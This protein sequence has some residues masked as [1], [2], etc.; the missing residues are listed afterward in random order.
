MIAVLLLVARM[1]TFW[2]MSPGPAPT[3]VRLTVR[4]P[5]FSRTVTSEIGSIVGTWLTGRT[6]TL[7]VREKVFTPP[8]AV[9]PLSVTVTVIVAVP[10]A[11]VTG[12]KSSV[13]VAARLTYVTIGL[14]T[15]AVL[16]L[17]A[18][19]LVTVCVAA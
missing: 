9:S 19:T 13:P 11:L 10:L 14:G 5:L 8:L 6:V 2:P 12:A 4:G 1:V 3:P 7:N 17:V 18:V 16:S 15:T